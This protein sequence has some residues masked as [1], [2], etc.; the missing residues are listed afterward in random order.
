MTSSNFADCSSLLP[1]AGHSP[2]AAPSAMN[3]RRLIDH[4]VH[5]GAFHSLPGDRT[6]SHGRRRLPSYRSWLRSHANDTQRPG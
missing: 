4:P 3:S 6:T 5:S 2:T 1:R